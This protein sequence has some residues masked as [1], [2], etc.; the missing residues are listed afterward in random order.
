MK[1]FLFP[2]PPVLFTC[3][4]SPAACHD[5]HYD[6][7]EARAI[8]ITLSLDDG[9]PFAD[10]PFAISPEGGGESL[11]AGHTDAHGR[12]VFLP[13]RSGRWR[14]TAFSEHGHGTE[15]FFETEETG[16]LGS[17]QRP[18]FDR[19]SRVIVGVSLIIGIFGAASLLRGRKRTGNNAHP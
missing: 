9:T 2:L 7:R 12:A 5:L 11:L 6:V 15:F 10:L 16:S 1:R 13:E 18:L 14:L 17:F 4:A 3:L 8:V 19:Y